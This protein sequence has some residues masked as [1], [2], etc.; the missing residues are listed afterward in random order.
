M[1]RH[2]ATPI[3]RSFSKT[4]V[5]F[6]LL[7]ATSS[8][9]LQA[10]PG[11]VEMVIHA[12]TPQWTIDRHIYSQFAEHLG[13]GIYEGVWVREDSSIPNTRGLRNDVVAALKHL[14]IPAIRWPGGCFAD[15]YHWRDGIGP[16]EQ[17]PVSVNTNWGGVTDDNA[18]GTHEFMDLVEQLD[19]E[20]YISGNLGGGSVQEMRDWVEYLTSDSAS[21]LANLRRQNGRDKPWKIAYF[22]IGNESWGCGG[23]MRPE[24]YADEYRRYAQYVGQANG[25]LPRIASGSSG[26]DFH[27]TDVLMKQASTMMHG[28]SLHYYT[29]P[30]GWAN[31]GLATSFNED[32][33]AETLRLTLHMDDLLVEHSKIM[34]RYD[35]EKKVG[36]MVDE[37][38]TWFAPEPGSNPG[39]LYQQNTLRDAMVAALNLNLFH[40]H[41]E[42]VRMTAIAQMV[43]VLQAMILTDKDRMLLTPTYHVFEMYKV[44]QDAT[45]IPIAFDTP[46]YRHGDIDLPMVSVTASRDAA[47]KLHVSLV[48]IDPSESI[49]LRATVPGMTAT[50]VSG[51]L[52][53][54]TAMNAH[55]TFD[56]PDQVHPVA[57]AGATLHDGRLDVQLPAKAIVTL[58]LR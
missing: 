16:R 25:S 17:R 45:F 56:K 46:R 42:R 21:T 10:A 49:S 36:L 48:N 5:V 18:F 54:A 50:Q 4:T 1:P 14:Q 30:G 52:L 35:P 6:G 7:A 44:H 57:F 55:N 28:L 51:R 33:W 22:G 12:D 34:D 13:R 23:A 9:H 37:W 53:T 47:G 27:W 24:Y 8:L 39:F 32:E 3:T 15:E 31:K 2:H 26:E 19:S 40:V 29:V 11:A 38:G 41:G 43:N 20:A 58:E